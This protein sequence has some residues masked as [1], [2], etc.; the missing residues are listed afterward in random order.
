MSTITICD[1][2]GAENTKH[3]HLATGYVWKDDKLLG[4]GCDLCD[5]HYPVNES[6]QPNNCKK[7]K[8]V[9]PS[10]YRKS[11]DLGLHI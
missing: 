6:K 3:I 7:I 9:W 8:F 2:C 4:Q 10:P 1:E 11:R 5:A